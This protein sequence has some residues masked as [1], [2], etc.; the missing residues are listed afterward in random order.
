MFDYLVAC[1]VCLANPI[2]CFSIKT[3]L[4]TTRKNLKGCDLEI[5]LGSELRE[6]LYFFKQIFKRLFI[7]KSSILNNF[8]SWGFLVLK[9][10][11]NILGSLKE[12]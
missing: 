5:E 6:E 3:L 8:P 4:I 7:S 10:D 9:M 12:F 11:G 2:Y 1:E